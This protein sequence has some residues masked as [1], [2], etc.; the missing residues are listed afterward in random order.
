MQNRHFVKTLLGFLGIITLG[1]I[2][3]FV[4]E[5]YETIKAGKAKAELPSK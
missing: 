4:L 1:L 2:G 5:N 3:F